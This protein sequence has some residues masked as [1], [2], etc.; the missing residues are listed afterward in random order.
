MN[1][2]DETIKYTKQLK[3]LYVEDRA[4]TRKYTKPMLED[5][6]DDIICAVNGQDGLEKFMQND[7]DMIITDINMPE[8]DGFDMIKQIKQKNK[9]VIVLVVSAYNEPEDFM[10][11]I[12]LGVDGYLLKPIDMDQFVE[13]LDKA[14]TKLKL[15]DE[16][17]KNL[18]LLRQYQETIDA[19]SIISK[20]DLSGNITYVN[21][22]FCE[23]SGYEKSELI[24]KNQ[25]IIR[26]P[27]NE[28][29]IYKNMWE[30]IKNKKSIWQGIVRNIDK[31]GNA[32]YVN[33]T[34]KPILDKNGEII[35]YISMRDDITSIMSPKKLLQDLID[36][37]EETIVV[38]IQIERFED[39]DK[40]CG[41]KMSQKIEA[42]FSKIIL[43]MLP[44]GCGF[45][46]IFNLGNGEFAFAKNKEDCYMGIEY[47]TDNLKIL[48]EKLTDTKINISDIDY[49]ISVVISMTYGENALENA[50]CGLKHIIET[51]QDFIVANNLL[52]LEHDKAEQNLK[53]LKMIKK[54]ID[55]NKIISYFQP[56]INNKTKQID[57]YESLVRLVDEDGAVIVPYFFLDVAKVGKYY[58]Q[59]TLMVLNNSF[60][61]LKYIPD[62][63]I[64]INL[65][66]LDIEKKSIRKRIFKLL[67]ENSLDVNR[68]VFELLEDEDVKDF[69]LVKSFIHDVKKMG[70]RIAI[71]DFGAGYSNFERLL[72]YEPD[73]LKIDGSLVKNVANDPF[74]LNVIE[75]IVSFAKK[76][77]L[78][79]V[80][81]YVENESIYNILNDIG[82]DYSQGYYFGKPQ[83]LY[84]DN[85]VTSY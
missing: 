11:G 59:I 31:D 12:K 39:I 21:D 23:I 58:S 15:M 53:T 33:A 76:Q 65:S 44:Q 3:L 26:H 69:K 80:A 36:Q 77:N 60:K 13:A 71:D 43:N 57:K 28:A 5:F 29:I 82:V 6:F 30:K 45:K 56:I 27:D 70:V 41:F 24:G 61:A 14:T 63:D 51:K 10:E 49:Y 55:N 67:E 16:A 74:C 85:K 54:A 64:S 73:I 46:K 19:S 47:V 68:I 50:K 32:Y 83:P 84:V 75:T 9:D 17:E 35:E 78:E 1:T 37:Y 25:N 81:E 40:F 18:N 42:K 38:M 48:Q 72:E 66:I 79:I 62:I 7:I 22:R 20:T 34:V 2:I 4:D 52:E 8:V